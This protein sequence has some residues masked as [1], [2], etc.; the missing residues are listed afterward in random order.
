MLTKQRLRSALLKV[1]AKPH[2]VTLAM[3]LFNVHG[4]KNALQFVRGLQVRGLT[5]NQSKP[6]K[7]AR[8][9]L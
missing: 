6:S 5:N 4:L 9:K 2:Q 3:T 7:T 1:G 8:K